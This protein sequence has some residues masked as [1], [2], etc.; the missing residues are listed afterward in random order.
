M[1]ACA[2]GKVGQQRGQL[3]PVQILAAAAGVDATESSHQWPRDLC[4]QSLEH[5]EGL[6]P[7]NLLTNSAIYLTEVS[8]M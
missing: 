1:D 8:L 7:P 6:H 2:D 5:D 3:R 4:E